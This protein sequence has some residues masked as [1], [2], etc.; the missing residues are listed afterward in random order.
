MEMRCNSATLEIRSERTSNLLR[1]QGMRGLGQVGDVHP[2]DKMLGHLMQM[3]WA[4]AV[5]R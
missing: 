4:E 1:I 3:R 2:Q 5:L